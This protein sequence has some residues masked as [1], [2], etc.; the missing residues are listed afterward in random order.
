MGKFSIQKAVSG[1]GKVEQKRPLLEAAPGPGS[2]K[3][4]IADVVEEQAPMV[5]KG[6]TRKL[7]ANAP[8]DVTIRKYTA[9][10]P[11]LFQSNAACV[12]FRGPS[13]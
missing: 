6:M 4:K 5:P 3:F 9:S 13:M 2:K 12:F 7:S 10:R 11:N 1:N 8:V